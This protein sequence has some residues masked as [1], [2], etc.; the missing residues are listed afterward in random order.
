MNIGE[1]RA[2]S[3]WYGLSRT[4]DKNP[5]LD[6]FFGNVGDL[7]DKRERE[8]PTTPWDYGAAAMDLAMPLAIA[9]APQKF[10]AQ[11][12]SP[13]IFSK[14]DASKI[15]TALKGYGTYLTENPLAVAAKGEHVYDVTARV[16]PWR[17]MDLRAPIS[18]QTPAV[19]DSLR[20]LGPFDITRQADDVV[21]EL[22]QKFGDQ[23]AAS[24]L[25]NSGI[26]GAF[27]RNPDRN[28]VMYDTTFLD[29]V[30]RTGW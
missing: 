12:V 26:P 6:F 14:L 30:L 4:I 10:V 25:N 20:K 28:F 2:L 21:R 17:L 29:P 27:W 18:K 23:R 8:Q 22:T 24:M 1:A 16:P 3:P 19:R 9:R 15:M 7:I 13:K 5:L 11:H